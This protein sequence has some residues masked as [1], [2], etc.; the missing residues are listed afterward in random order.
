MACRFG[1]S[2]ATL[3][4]EGEARAEPVEIKK[5]N[6]VQTKKVEEIKTFWNG[7][8]SEINVECI[9]VDVVITVSIANAHGKKEIWTISPRGKMT[10]KIE[11]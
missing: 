11:Y 2:F 1:E 3:I 4:S 9:G 6:K 10:S 7:T 8:D 5:M